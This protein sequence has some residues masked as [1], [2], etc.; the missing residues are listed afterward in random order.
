MYL[1]IRYKIKIYELCYK[2]KI[3]LASDVDILG[4]LASLEMTAW[5]RRERREGVSAATPLKRTTCP[6]LLLRSFRAKREI[7]L[8]LIQL[9]FLIL[10]I[11]TA[12]HLNL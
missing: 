6:K 3:L 12:L 2:K 9:I 8:L 7:S 11:I 4:F 10:L 5:R 1:L